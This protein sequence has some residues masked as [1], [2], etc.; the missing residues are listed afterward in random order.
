MGEVYGGH[1]REREE[2]Q[3]YEEKDQCL[4]LTIFVTDLD[5]TN[6]FVAMVFLKP[7]LKVFEYN[8]KEVIRHSVT[9]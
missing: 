5:L 7:L 3:Q 6:D 1:E 2:F 9:F 4:L 8:T